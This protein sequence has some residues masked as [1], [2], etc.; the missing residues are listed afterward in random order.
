[1]Y[2]V[3]IKTSDTFSCIAYMVTLQFIQGVQ[4]IGHALQ[5]QL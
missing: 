3:W 2:T 4:I 5:Q 1:M